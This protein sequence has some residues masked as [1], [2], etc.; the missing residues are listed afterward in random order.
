MGLRGPFDALTKLAAQPEKDFGELVW[1]RRRERRLPVAPAG[2]VFPLCRC[3]AMT[4]RPKARSWI[5][6][7][8]LFLHNCLITIP[9]SMN[10]AWPI[11]VWPPAG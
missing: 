4:M 1:R 3:G 9:H 5:R 8:R 6:W 2:K 10:C 7:R 11:G